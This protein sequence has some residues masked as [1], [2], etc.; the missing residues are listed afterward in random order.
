[1]AFVYEINGQ[2]VEFEKEPTQEDNDEAARQL[3]AAPAAPAAPPKSQARQEAEGIATMLAVPAMQAVQ[4]AIENPIT[5]A[6]GLY[7][8]YKGSQLANAGIDALKSMKAPPTAAPVPAPVAPVAPA[9]SPILGANGQPIV[10]PVAPV[11]PPAAAPA[12]A[13]TGI[14]DKA[15]QMV[16]QL[17]ANRVVQGAARIGGT[18]AAA[19]TPGNIGQN[20]NFPQ[21]GP[22]AGSEINPGT[23]RPWT[24]QELDAYR[25]R[26]GG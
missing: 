21:S 15:A 7:G 23:G 11:A 8:A 4:T 25:T 16:R 24:Q 6:T 5:T 12:P 10:R 20:Y 13:Q 1:M 22:L 17:A 9:T 18:A 3:G 19:L 2:R 14:M 26:F